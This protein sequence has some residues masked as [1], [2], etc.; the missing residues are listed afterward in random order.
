MKKNDPFENVITIDGPGGAG[1]STLAQGLAHALDWLCLDTGAIY[2][3][4]A[5]TLTELGLPDAT[6]RAAGLTA[7]DMGLEFR[8]EGAQCRL[9]LH[10]REPGEALRAPEIGLLASAVSAWPEV[11]S[12]LLPIQR[13]AG[14]EGRLVAEGRDMG[15]VVFPEAR[16]KFFLVADLSVRAE[17]RRLELAA[18]GVEVTLAKVTAELKARDLADATRSLAPLAP[19]PGAVTVDSTDMTVAEVLALALQEA[20]ETFDL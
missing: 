7:Q 4:L 11:R 10:G 5:L 14:R 16:L 3:A 6:P 12:A 1:K 18:Q 9:F 17:R 13:A 19:S 15:T 8:R 2:R 20:K